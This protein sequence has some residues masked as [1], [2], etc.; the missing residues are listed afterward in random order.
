MRRSAFT[1]FEVILA[2]AILVGAMAVLGELVRGGL[3][4]AR[5]AR[6]LSRATLMAEAKVAQLVA[7]IQAPEPVTSM[8]VEDDYSGEWVYSLEV[9]QTSSPELVAVRVT[10]ERSALNQR[11]AV[12]CSLV[13]WIRLP[14]TTS[15]TS[16]SSSSSTGSTSGGSS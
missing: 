4:S 15:T 3:D 5:R 16:S 9:S 1:L 14:T 2:L 6:D 13:R 10:V 7:G 8:P 12:A 11:R